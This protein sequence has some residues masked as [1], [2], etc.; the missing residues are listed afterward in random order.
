[1]RD[2][3]E[4]PVETESDFVEVVKD[5]LEKQ[6]LYPGWL[7][8]KPGVP[9]AANLYRFLEGKSSIRLAGLAAVFHL[10]GISLSVDTARHLN[11]QHKKG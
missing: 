3:D 2:S 5:E 9:S 6:G 4:I 8:G 10:L 11:S 1:L 7:L